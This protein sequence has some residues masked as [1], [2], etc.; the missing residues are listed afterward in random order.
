[1]NME[2]FWMKQI[3]KRSETLLITMEKSI[4]WTLFCT[5]KTPIYWNILKLWILS[6]EYIGKKRLTW[7]SGLDSLDIIVILTKSSILSEYLIWTKMDMW[8]KRNLSGWPLIVKLI[9]RRLIYYLRYHPIML[10]NLMVLNTVI[11]QRMDLNG[12]GKLDYEEFTSLIFKQKERKMANLTTKRKYSK[13]K[14]N[15]TKHRKESRERSSAKKT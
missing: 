9:T 10:Q 14:M 1:M 2:F 13:P 15:S 11:I 3:L 12:N 5:L 8:I 6:V 4:D 7:L